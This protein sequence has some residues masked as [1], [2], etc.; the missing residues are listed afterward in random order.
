[1]QYLDIPAIVYYIDPMAL[2]NNLSRLQS[3]SPSEDKDW[4][5]WPNKIVSQTYSINPIFDSDV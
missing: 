3:G 4:Y 5:P 2:L 1:M